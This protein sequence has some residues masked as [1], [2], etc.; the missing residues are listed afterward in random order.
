MVGDRSGW[1]SRVR[2]RRVGGQLIEVVPTLDLVVV[3]SSFQEA[4]NAEGDALTQMVSYAVAPTLRNREQSSL[5]MQQRWPVLGVH[6]QHRRRG[7]GPALGRLTATSGL[8]DQRAS[9]FQGDQPVT[10]VTGLR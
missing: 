4:G 7:S 5:P 2:S 3:V 9:N 6:R 10:A 1:P 8:L